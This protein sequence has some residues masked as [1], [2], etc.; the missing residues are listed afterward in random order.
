MLSYLDSTTG[1]LKVEPEKKLSKLSSQIGSL[2]SY[3]LGLLLFLTH[4]NDLT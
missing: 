4:I 2:Q 3:I 1:A